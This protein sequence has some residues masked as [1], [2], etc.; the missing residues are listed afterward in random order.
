VS[1]LKIRNGIA[2]DGGCTF[3]HKGGQFATKEI[4][5]QGFTPVKRP[6]SGTLTEQQKNI[7]EYS[8]QSE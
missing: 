5:I 8:P 1:G 3:N 2:G 6:P 7:I 4:P